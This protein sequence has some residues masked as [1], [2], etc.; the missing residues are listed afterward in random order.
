MGTSRNCGHFTVSLNIS[1]GLHNA[2][3][4]LGRMDKEFRDQ[5][6]KALIKIKEKHEKALLKEWCD[7]I[8]WDEE[9][10]AAAVAAAEADRQALLDADREGR[11]EK[12]RRRAAARV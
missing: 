6:T 4:Q 7:A 12:R 1:G 9:K 11:E 5:F 10:A 8:G 3:G 2:S